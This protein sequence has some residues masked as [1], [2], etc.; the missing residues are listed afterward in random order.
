MKDYCPDPERYGRPIKP[1]E[2]SA[3]EM[4]ME[5]LL[6]ATAPAQTPAPALPFDPETDMSVGGWLAEAVDWVLDK[7]EWV[8]G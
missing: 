7:I 1:L 6:E 4:P 5:R 2:R 8:F 3:P